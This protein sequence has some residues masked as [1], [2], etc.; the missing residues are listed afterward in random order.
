MNMQQIQLV[1]L[2][3]LGIMGILLVFLLRKISQV[4][5]QLEIMQKNVEKY[6]TYIMEETEEEQKVSKYAPLH[7]SKSK[8]KDDEEKNELIQNVLK[9]IFS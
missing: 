7:T 4:K 6:V 5:K 8:L 9:E 2:A 1:I 3:T